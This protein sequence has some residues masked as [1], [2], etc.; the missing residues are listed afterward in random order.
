MSYPN[1]SSYD[2][3]DSFELEMYESSL[4]V[5]EDPKLLIEQYRSA[6]I[7]DDEIASEL[8]VKL[9][10]I[11]FEFKISEL[12]SDY[13][14]FEGK[15]SDFE[16]KYYRFIKNMIEKGTTYLINCSLMSLTK[17]CDDLY[18]LCLEKTENWS[19][20]INRK[21]FDG[22]TM[23]NTAVRYQSLE[24]VKKLIELGA[25]VSES[26]PY[27]DDKLLCLSFM[28]GNIETFDYLL[29]LNSEE[30]W[31][32][33][34]GK[35]LYE[36]LSSLF[37]EHELFDRNIKL[38]QVILQKYSSAE[39]LLDDILKRSDISAQFNMALHLFIEREDEYYY[40]NTI[41]FVLLM[42]CIKNSTKEFDMSPIT[43]DEFRELFAFFYQRCK[44]SISA[45][46]HVI[47]STLSDA[48]IID[49]INIIPHPN[50][51]CRV[52][53]E[54]NRDIY[55]PFYFKFSNR[56]AILEALIKNPSI[57][58]YQICKTNDTKYVSERSNFTILNYVFEDMEK[59]DIEQMRVR[60][61]E[62]IKFLLSKHVSYARTNERLNEV[63]KY[64]ESQVKVKEISTESFKTLRKSGK[65]HDI[66]INQCV[67]SNIATVKNI[68]KISKFKS[69]KTTK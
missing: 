17:R 31:N 46:D 8:E 64:W 62:V 38:M 32:E 5:K 1:E 24:V 29:G 56:I 15:C 61:Q 49:M 52:R 69:M 51:I 47:T 7:N 21:R 16:Q 66:F 65:L 59:T 43:D 25:H 22:R 44:F 20:F 54:Q 3:M 58:F 18:L 11:E 4:P 13:E 55:I 9:S 27:P 60:Y 36:L 48:Q 50:F 67:Q 23:L 68:L 35:L 63:V 14:Y 33:K 57:D 6:L 39:T 42:R 30:G 53:D 40:K 10:M 45:V 19:E 12:I 28:S 2:E 26:S 41:P 37:R 34:K